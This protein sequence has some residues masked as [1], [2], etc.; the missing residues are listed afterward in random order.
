MIDRQL[1]LAMELPK[2]EFCLCLTREAKFEIPPMSPPVEV[3][4]GDACGDGVG[5]GGADSGDEVLQ[6]QRVEAG[7]GGVVGDEFGAIPRDG[8]LAFSILIT[9]FSQSRIA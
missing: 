5:A 6:S 4:F 9:H 8:G 2:S 1:D 7:L 3:A